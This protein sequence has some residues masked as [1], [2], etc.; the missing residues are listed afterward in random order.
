MVVNEAA[1]FV[2]AM[3]GGVQRRPLTC[4]VAIEP[5]ELFL[6]LWRE[7]NRAGLHQALAHAFLYSLASRTLTF[8]EVTARD[9]SALIAS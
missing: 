7:D 2:T 1:R 8:S 5:G 4:D 9:G 3:T 6:R